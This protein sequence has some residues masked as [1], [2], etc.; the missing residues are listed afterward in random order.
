MIVG[1]RKQPFAIHRHVVNKIP[2]LRERF[3]ECD[4][5]I[6]SITGSMTMSEVD[7]MAFAVAIDFAYHGRLDEE[8]IMAKYSKPDDDDDDDETDTEE[9]DQGGDTALNAFLAH[10]QRQDNKP[11]EK[12]DEKDDHKDTIEDDDEDSILP[13]YDN[14]L[15]SVFDLAQALQ[16]EY[17]A[18]A[19]ID[20]YVRVLAADPPSAWGLLYLQRKGLQNSRLMH[21][22]LR[23]IAWCIH[24][25]GA[26]AWEEHSFMKGWVNESVGN[27]K[28]VMRAMAEY[29]GEQGG[30]GGG[31]GPGGGG[32][33]GVECPFVEGGIDVCVEY[34]CHEGTERCVPVGRKKKGGGGGK[35]VAKANGKRVKKI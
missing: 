17:L 8:N 11:D 20:A 33:G 30:G 27:G 10:Q 34:H 12:A 9:G 1:P 16:Y 15:V 23:A 2:L 25:E 18:N 7:T 21:L 3:L 29:R 26:E 35:V 4:D 14:L 32:G 5:S 19:T 13:T 31:G 28:L 24:A 6:E 22:M